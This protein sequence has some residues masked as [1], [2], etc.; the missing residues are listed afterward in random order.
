MVVGPRGRPV[1]GAVF[2]L[3]EFQSVFFLRSRLKENLF[4]LMCPPIYFSSGVSEFSSFLI[5]G[6]PP[7]TVSYF[8]V[9]FFRYLVTGTL[10]GLCKC[11]RLHFI[12][13][14]DRRPPPLDEGWMY[15]FWSRYLFSLPF[16]VVSSLF[17]VLL[18][19]SK[20]FTENGP[21]KWI[22]PVL[23]LHSRADD[24]VTQLLPSVRL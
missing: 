4:S 16:F 3:R 20:L 10:Y 15:P 14:P 1:C 5:R 12:I 8:F 22:R 2:F 17:P 19:C 18:S 7:L 9:P 13:N 23:L 11:S 6:F 24:P 21:A